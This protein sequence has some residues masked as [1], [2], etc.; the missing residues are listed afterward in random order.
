VDT[1][2]DVTDSTPDFRRL[3][4]LRPSRPGLTSATASALKMNTSSSP[5][6][7]AITSPAASGRQ[8]LTTAE[9]PP[10]DVTPSS[11]QGLQTSRPAAEGRRIARWADIRDTPINQSSTAGRSSSIPGIPATRKL[12]SRL[13]M[14]YEE[15][16][17]ETDM[18]VMSSSAMEKIDVSRTSAAV[19]TRTAASDALTRATPAGDEIQTKYSSRPATRTV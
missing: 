7:D 18:D 13:M 4:R 17:P 11:N 2:I 14:E 15:P 5:P 3:L 10:L 6:T 16:E 12:P 8:K 9:S 19:R 1:S